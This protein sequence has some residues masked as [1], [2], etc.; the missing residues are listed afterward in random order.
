MRN[1]QGDRVMVTPSV[2][3]ASEAAVLA[4][5]GG[6]QGHIFLRTDGMWSDGRTAFAY[7]I[8]DSNGEL[9]YQDNDLSSAASSA[10]EGM[11]SLVSFL[12]AC[13]E[14]E[15][16]ESENYSLFPASVREWAEMV[17]DE[18]TMISLEIEE[19]LEQ[20]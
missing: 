11:Q 6:E 8:Y 2:L 20:S 17:S 5:D 19:E 18:L 9:L 1:E 3:Y 14:S 7:C 15:S 16:E 13:A 12:L 10:L 4:V